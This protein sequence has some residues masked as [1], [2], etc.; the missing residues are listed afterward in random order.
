MF[1]ERDGKMLSR[2]AVDPPGGVVTVPVRPGVD[3]L[4]GGDAHCPGNGPRRIMNMSHT[5]GLKRPECRYD[6]QQTIHC[7]SPIVS[8][9]R[10]ARRMDDA[11][12][13]MTRG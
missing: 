13:Q 6:H 7:T 9:R 8:D 5:S 11:T 3:D 12:H 10:R 2:V 4:K 1:V